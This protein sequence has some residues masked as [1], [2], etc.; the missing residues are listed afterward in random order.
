MDIYQAFEQFCSLI[1][2]T[3]GRYNDFVKLN[4]NFLISL[5][6]NNNDTYGKICDISKINEINEENFALAFHKSLIE[7]YNSMKNASSFRKNGEVLELLNIL[8]ANNPK[9]FKA[10]LSQEVRTFMDFTLHSLAKNTVPVHNTPI[11]TRSANPS[12]QKRSINSV[13]NL[14]D[15]ENE[16][17]NDENNDMD[18][19]SEMDCGNAT[20]DKNDELLLLKQKI[21]TLTNEIIRLKSNDKVNNSNILNKRRDF[22]LQETNIMC[23]RNIEKI[24]KYHNHIN[25]FKTH[26]ENE[27]T[28][29]ALFFRNFPKPFLSDDENFINEYNDLVRKF[30][31]E[32]MKMSIRYLEERIKTKEEYIQ[33]I[34]K[35]KNIDLSTIE[36]EIIENLKPMFNI[37]QEKALRARSI[38]FSVQNY[39]NA[40]NRNI[41]TPN[42][43]RRS[44]ISSDIS[45]SSQKSV[46]F[47]E[48]ISYNYLNNNQTRHRENSQYHFKRKN[49]QSLNNDYSQESAQNTRY[50][51]RSNSIT[52]SKRPRNPSVSPLAVSSKKSAQPHRSEAS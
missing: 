41:Q 50:N 11:S 9:I 16:E 38:P 36:E 51:T 46:R 27:T 13:I 6:A 14:N 3:K 37:K 8:Y 7:Y 23:K 43:S 21:E 1:L 35:D 42:R 24:H 25:L 19:E 10:Q 45:E 44:S 49:H 48:T 34:S 5:K 40:I 12:R 32:A 17:N 18:N 20:N 29:P 15:D 52:Y 22:T 33:E 47:N 4:K 28:P 30:Q 39:P 2:T 26:I 31:N